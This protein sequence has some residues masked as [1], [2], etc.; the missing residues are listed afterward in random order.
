[1]CKAQI[2]FLNPDPLEAEKKKE[3]INHETTKG[4]KHEKETV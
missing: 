2:F 4:R 1:M 3:K